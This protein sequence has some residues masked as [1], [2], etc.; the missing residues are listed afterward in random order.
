LGPLGFGVRV[1]VALADGDSD[2]GGDSLEA[3]V[4]ASVAVVCAT[5]DCEGAVST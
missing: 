4:G 2:G 5:G 1:G 3:A